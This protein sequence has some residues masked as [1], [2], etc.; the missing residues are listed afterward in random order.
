MFHSDIIFEE[1]K[2]SITSTSINII[3]LINKGFKWVDYGGLHRTGVP[4]MIYVIF[5]SINPETRIG[6]LN[7]KGKL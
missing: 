3:W 7:F 5:K 2:D 6:A 1:I 4:T